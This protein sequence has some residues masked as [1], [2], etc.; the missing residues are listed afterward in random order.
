MLFA[1]DG[2]WGHRCYFHSTDSGDIDVIFTER[3][4]EAWMLFSLN[5]L[6]RYKFYFH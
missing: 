3:I 6:W 2:L 5:G 1:L 4:M